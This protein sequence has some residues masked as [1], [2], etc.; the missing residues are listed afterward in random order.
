[1]SCFDCNRVAN[2]IRDGDCSFCCCRQR[3]RHHDAVR[4]QQQAGVFS[5]QL[6]VG[7]GKLLD[8]GGRQCAFNELA[9]GF[10][11]DLGDRGLFDQR[12]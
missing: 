4:R 5:R 11:V 12:F 2:G 1:M 8:R 3:T 6:C 7:A 9:G 10:R